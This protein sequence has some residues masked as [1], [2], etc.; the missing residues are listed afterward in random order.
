MSAIMQEP[1]ADPAR[2][3]YSQLCVLYTGL[4]FGVVDPLPGEDVRSRMYYLG[5]RDAYHV[6]VAH[7]ASSCTLRDAAEKCAAFGVGVAVRPAVHPYGAE[8]CAGFVETA[9]EAAAD[10]TMYAASGILPMV[11]LTRLK[12][13]RAAVRHMSP[14]EGALSTQPAILD[15]PPRSHREW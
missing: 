2:G 4:S 5:R 9:R 13:A 12:A 11:D 10:L 6:V 15:E 14:P 8:W 3:H 7:L 1:P